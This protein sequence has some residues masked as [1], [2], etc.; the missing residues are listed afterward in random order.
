MWKI[1]EK[2]SNFVQRKST[3]LISGMKIIMKRLI[4]ALHFILCLVTIVISS[5]G[6]GSKYFDP[7]RVGSI[8]CGS[9]RVGLGQPFMVWVWIWKISPKNVKFSIFCPSGQKNL[10]R[11]G[12]KV[13][14]SE[15]GQPLIYSGSKVSSG[16]VRAHL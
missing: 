9:G 1:L 11:S 3:K 14:E 16:Q 10:F 12:R 6:S 7:G 8:F 4:L 2:N 13:P 5:D 15:A